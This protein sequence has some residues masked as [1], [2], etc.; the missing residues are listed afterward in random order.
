MLILQDN[1]VT[2]FEKTCTWIRNGNLK[3]VTESI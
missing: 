3:R 1:L 2:S